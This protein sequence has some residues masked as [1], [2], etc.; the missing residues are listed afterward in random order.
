MAV[1]SVTCVFVVLL[2]VAALGQ[3]FDNAGFK[4]AL[5][6]FEE[7]SKSDGLSPC[8][9]KKAITFLDR[10]GRTE[11]FAVSDEITIVQ[12]PEA[13]NNVTTVAEE[14]IEAT[15]PRDLQA[16]DAALST[17][18][19]D[20]VSSVVKNKNIEFNLPT[21]SEIGAEEGN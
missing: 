21:L 19:W 12:D 15:L 6:V 1:R 7:C 18:L 8:L 11:K 3:D 20:K 9:K 5:K 17:L 13:V 4:V 14:N 16:R 10:L 2:A